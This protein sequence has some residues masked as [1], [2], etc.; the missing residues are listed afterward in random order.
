MT[1]ISSSTIDAIITAIQAHAQNV[2]TCNAILVTVAS[3][4]TASSSGS[5]QGASTPGT[6]GMPEVCQACVCPHGLT[7]AASPVTPAVALAP[8]AGTPLVAPAPAAGTAFYAVLVEHATGIFSSLAL[9]QALTTRVSGNMYYK[10]N[11]CDEAEGA[12]AKAERLGLVHT[13]N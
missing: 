13:A 11:S 10:F 3:T 2:Q 8:A 7:V 4:L 6:S 9:V 5:A 12:Y 1:D